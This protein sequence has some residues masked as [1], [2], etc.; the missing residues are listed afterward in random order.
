MSVVGI[1]WLAGM[2]WWV[3]TPQLAPGVVNPYWYVFWPTFLLLLS[4]LSSF[5]AT[6]M[7]LIGDRRKIESNLMYGLCGITLALM[8]MGLNID[9]PEMTSEQFRTHLWLAMADLVGILIGC[10]LSIT[11]FAIV[12]YLYEKSLPQP[13]SIAPPSNDELELAAAVISRHIGGEQE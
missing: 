5:S 10:L 2:H 12:I 6:A 1:S 4:C 3:L 7:L 8:L 9:G 13:S 11:A